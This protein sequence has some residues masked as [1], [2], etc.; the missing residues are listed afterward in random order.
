MA[1]IVIV[2]L[3]NPGS[4]GARYV[5]ASLRA[6]G[7]DVWLLHFKE[8]R[9]KMVPSDQG[10]EDDGQDNRD[11]MYV[12]IRRPGAYICLPYTTRITDREK[13]LFLGELERLKPDLVGFS[14]Y[15]VTAP[16]AEELTARIHAALP[17]TPVLW[18]GIHAILDPEDAIAH[19]D[20]VCDGEGEEV[21]VELLE[22]WDEYRAAGALDLPGLWFRRGDEV[23]RNPRRPACQDLDRLAFPQYAVQELM[24]DDDVLS[25][26]FSHKGEHT[27]T[28]I[29]VFTERGCPFH[30]SYCVH[31]ILHEDPSFSRIRRRSVD[32]VLEECEGLYADHGVRHF[33]IHDEIF[34]IQK[35]WIR[36]FCEKFRARFRVR[37]CSFTGYVHPQTTDAEMIEW[38]WQAGMTVT[39]MGV[40]TG[41][42]RV[43][44]EV[45]ERP[46]HPEKTIE[47]SRLLAR[48]PFEKVQYEM[49]VYNP[50]ETEAERRETFDFL[51][52]LAPPFDI[53]CFDLV[54]YPTCKLGRRT[55][56]EGTLDMG[57]MT[58]YNM[59]Y[60]LAGVA[61]IERD[62]LRRWADD[63]WYREHPEALEAVAIPIIRLHEEQRRLRN[64][65]HRLQ[66][67]GPYAYPRP[68]DSLKRRLRRAASVL[69]GR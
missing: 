42:P 28:N 22:R 53:E 3:Y 19:A 7:H 46:F 54:L 37:G 16:I 39:G 50:F 14:F 45:F 24:I 15:T 9:F 41:S 63:P 1:R 17:G 27:N 56:P 6:A 20:I 13:E 68:K 35:P 69:L 30:C 67:T 11:L 4:A 33:L 29:L 18:G 21:T 49:L 64:E 61:E 55:P 23:V 26:K 2:T 62:A 59:L 60:F 57:E 43:A 5:A 34:A 52:K 12:R 32:N 25:D 40:Q 38:L 65:T 8:F 48:Y 58:F 36:E 10:I 47:M 51:L 31:S 66:G 44:S